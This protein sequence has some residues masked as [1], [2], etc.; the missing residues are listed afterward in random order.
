VQ[1]IV[2]VAIVYMMCVLYDEVSCFGWVSEP[3]ETAQCK[4]D[5]GR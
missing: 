2:V 5:Y 3:H 1:L 4:I